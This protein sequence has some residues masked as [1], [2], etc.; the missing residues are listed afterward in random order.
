[1]T[2]SRNDLSTTNSTDKIRV[3]MYNLGASALK[4]S[5]VEIGKL[6]TINKS[7]KSIDI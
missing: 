2:I 4:V 1:M 6:E 7:G 5:L 3:I